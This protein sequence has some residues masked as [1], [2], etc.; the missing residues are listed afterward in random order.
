MNL[1]DGEGKPRQKE[2]EMNDHRKDAKALSTPELRDQLAF[3]TEGLSNLGPDTPAW[4]M[5][6]WTAYAEEWNTRG[7]K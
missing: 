4:F 5:E 6:M 1:Q 7:A 3:L 2:P